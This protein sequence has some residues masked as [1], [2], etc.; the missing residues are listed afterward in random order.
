MPLIVEPSKP[1]LCH[2]ERF[3]NLKIKDLLFMLETSK[4]IHRKVQTNSFMATCDTK[5]GYDHVN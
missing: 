4:D 5:S 3:I 1:I 2:D